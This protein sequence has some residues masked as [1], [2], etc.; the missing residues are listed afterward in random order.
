MQRSVSVLCAGAMHTIMCDLAQ[1][2]R[3]ATAIDVSLTFTRSGAV[4]DRVLA[5]ATPDVV[6]TT[7]AAIVDLERQMKL[8]AGATAAVASSGIGVAV[9]AGAA[10]PDIS[11]VDAFIRLLRAAGSIAY[12]DPATGSPSGNYLAP[13]FERLGLAAELTPKTRL[14]GAAGADA[15]VVCEAVARGEAE[16]GLQQIGEILPVAGVELLGPLPQ[17]VQHVTVFSAGITIYARD[18]RA[19]RRLVGFVASDAAAPVIRAAGM[20]TP[21][22]LDSPD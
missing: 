19:A 2:F 18:E 17:Y 9:R 11:S 12:A 4:R 3:Q 21:E 6:V 22:R 8:A 5:G 20:E 15:V 13:L 16:I 14:I 7:L 1:R 10:R